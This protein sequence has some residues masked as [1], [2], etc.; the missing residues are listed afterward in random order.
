MGG[1]VAASD[2]SKDPGCRSLAGGR[3][4]SLEPL[5]RLASMAASDVSVPPLQTSALRGIGATG[6]N[7][8]A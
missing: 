3:G 4:I 8:S 5:G 7:G 6:L 1:V 2:V